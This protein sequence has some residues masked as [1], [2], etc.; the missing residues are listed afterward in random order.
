VHFTEYNQSNYITICVDT[1]VTQHSTLLAIFC[2]LET[3]F[4]LVCTSSC[5]QLYKNKNLHRNCVP[6]G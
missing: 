3:S 2:C 1:S 6:C 4:Y 5:V